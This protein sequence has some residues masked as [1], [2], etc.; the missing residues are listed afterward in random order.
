[1]FL[2]SICGNWFIIPIIMCIF[3]FIM[4]GKRRFKN[5]WMNNSFNGL[6]K[7][8]DNEIPLDILKKRYAKGEL[9]KD[10]FESMKDDLLD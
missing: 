1:M 9:S 4:F 6:I 2:E 10:E 3:C 5:N 7:N 8:S